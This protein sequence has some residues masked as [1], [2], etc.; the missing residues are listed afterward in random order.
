[1]LFPWRPVKNCLSLQR[2]VK[3]V[4]FERGL[5]QDSRIIRQQ[6]IVQ[7]GRI[8]NADKLFTSI[9]RTLPTRES[10]THIHS[11]TWLSEKNRGERERQSPW[12]HQSLQIH[13][14]S[15]APHHHSRIIRNSQSGL[16]NHLQTFLT[17]LTHLRHPHQRPPNSHHIHRPLILLQSINQNEKSLHIGKGSEPLLR[18]KSIRGCA[19]SQRQ[20][21][22]LRI[23]D[24]IIHDLLRNSPWMEPIRPHPVVLRRRYHH[25]LAVIPP[26]GICCNYRWL[27]AQQ[28]LRRRDI[29]VLL[30]N[31]R[32][33]Q[34][35]AHPHR[36]NSINRSYIKSQNG[37]RRTFTTPGTQHQRAV[38]LTGSA[39]VGKRRIKERF[40]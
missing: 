31:Q 32:A 10:I 4:L 17:F 7:Q 29:A 38:H 9:W 24:G 36:R 22:Q 6:R 2:G 28:V 21:V 3:A 37:I 34:S 8:V 20:D 12:L 30:G 25:R 1:M 14:T 16:H 40:V 5:Q 27:H 35:H 13:L 26:L 19:L 39:T 23:G 11:F 15:T 18:P 33:H